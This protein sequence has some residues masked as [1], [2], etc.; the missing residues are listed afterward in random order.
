MLKFLKVY[1]GASINGSESWIVKVTD[2][3]EIQ[4]AEMKFFKM[5]WKVAL[6]YIKE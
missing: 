4:T 3:T 1:G 2:Q 5:L 6:K